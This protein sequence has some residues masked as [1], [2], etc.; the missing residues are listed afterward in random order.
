MRFLV[1]SK[2]CRC[3]WSIFRLNLKMTVIAENEFVPLVRA[4]VPMLIVGRRTCNRIHVF[5]MNRPFRYELPLPGSVKHSSCPACSRLIICHGC[6]RAD[7]WITDLH[8]KASRDLRRAELNGTLSRMNRPA[9]QASIQ[10][11]RMN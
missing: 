7:S 6:F 3:R 10:G 1:M 9:V 2:G 4:A 11:L 8:T 5:C